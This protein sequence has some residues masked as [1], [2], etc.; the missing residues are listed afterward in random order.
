M[1]VIA[2]SRNSDEA[3]GVGKRASVVRAD[4][5]EADD[6]DVL[7]LTPA[8]ASI[9]RYV[10]GVPALAIGAAAGVATYLLRASSS[11]G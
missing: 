2:V 5:P 7:A 11:D 3:Q 9:C 1:D 6:A 10:L 8:N 4:L